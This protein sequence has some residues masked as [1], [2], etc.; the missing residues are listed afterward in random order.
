MNE[1]VKKKIEDLNN[2]EAETVQKYQEAFQMELTVQELLDMSY[3]KVVKNQDTYK[4]TEVTTFS[5][6]ITI[7]MSTLVPLPHFRKVDRNEDKAT[8][9]Y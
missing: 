5:D 9:E 3:G 4:F 6:Y 7:A 2:E 1:T 8:K